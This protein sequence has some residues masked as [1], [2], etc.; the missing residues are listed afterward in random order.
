[1][2]TFLVNSHTMAFQL[3]DFKVCLIALIVKL[4]IF[5][6]QNCEGQ[7]VLLN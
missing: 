4:L 1:M 3:F 7:L 2:H 6:Q 5:K